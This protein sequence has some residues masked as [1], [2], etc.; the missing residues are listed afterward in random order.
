MAIQGANP[1]LD[2]MFGQV[3]HAAIMCDP[4]SAGR[5]GRIVSPGVV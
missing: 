5:P 1:S 2:D 3:W 4:C